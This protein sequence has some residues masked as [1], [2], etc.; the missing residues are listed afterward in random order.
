[1]SDDAGP[2]SSF[3]LVMERLRKQDAEEGVTVRP[4]TD[5]QKSAIAEVRSLYDSR[6]AEQDVLQQSA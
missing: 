4:M 1:M 5:E 2:K 6:I 3:E